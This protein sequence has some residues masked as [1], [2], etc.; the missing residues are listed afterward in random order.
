MQERGAKPGP[1]PKAG[2]MK[3]ILQPRSFLHGLA[4]NG[5][6]KFGA[7]FGMMCCSTGSG[8]DQY[9]VSVL[10]R[11]HEN[12][13]KLKGASNK[14]ADLAFRDDHFTPMMSEPAFYAC[15]DLVSCGAGFDGVRYPVDVVQPYVDAGG[16]GY[17]P[18]PISSDLYSLRE[19]YAGVSEEK[20]YLPTLYYH[21]LT[22]S[23]VGSVTPIVFGE[24]TLPI[25]GNGATARV[26]GS[27]TLNMPF[28][29]DLSS[30]NSDLKVW[31]FLIL[32]K[33]QGDVPVYTTGRD[34]VS[35]SHDSLT[36]TAMQLGVM[37]DVKITI[38]DARIFPSGLQLHPFAC[39]VLSRSLDLIRRYFRGCHAV[40]GRKVRK[41]TLDGTGLLIKS[42]G[43]SIW[44]TGFKKYYNDLCFELQSII[45]VALFIEKYHSLPT[46]FIVRVGKAYFSNAQ[47]FPMLVDL[48][49]KNSHDIVEFIHEHIIA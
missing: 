27:N 5:F 29:R 44:P 22:F 42:S 23:Q 10:F 36:P 2:W 8:S 48:F 11:T 31:D 26:M 1:A 21:A 3:N 37:K 34:W 7:L 6:V 20:V 9:T 12:D 47:L 40:H 24:M 49:H 13:A 28:P 25:V 39:I 41:V 43:G 38:N 32:V 15:M 45:C 4:A 18:G 46:D 30:I 14:L 16:V 19:W 17:T 35:D 33:P